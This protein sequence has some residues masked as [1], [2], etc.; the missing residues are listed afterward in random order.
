[1]DTPPK[2]L[3]LEDDVAVAEDLRLKVGQLGYHVM[4]VVRDAAHALILAQSQKP[5]LALVDIVIHGEMDGIQV[6]ERFKPLGIPVIYI[7]SHADNALLERA[8]ITEPYGFILK[9]YSIRELQANIAMAL[10]KA[11]ASQKIAEHNQLYATLFS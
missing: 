2:I 4:G 5:D 11:E 1:M 9:P 3:I 7:T 10:Y 6:A 8:K